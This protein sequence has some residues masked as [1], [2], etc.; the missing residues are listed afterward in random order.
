VETGLSPPEAVVASVGRVTVR[1]VRVAT[2]ILKSKEAV[3]LALAIREFLDDMPRCV[4]ATL[5]LPAVIQYL[6]ARG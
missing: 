1:Y 3:P 4:T 6:K 5:K 2:T